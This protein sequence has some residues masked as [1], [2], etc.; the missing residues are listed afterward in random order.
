MQVYLFF[1]F[2][3]SFTNQTKPNPHFPDKSHTKPSIYPFAFVPPPPLSA[4]NPALFRRFTLAPRP[5]PNRQNYH[6]PK[7][8]KSSRVPFFFGL[9][10]NRPYRARTKPPSPKKNSVRWP[11]VR[12]SLGKPG[13]LAS[14]SLHLAQTNVRVISET[15]NEPMRKER[16][17]TFFSL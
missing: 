17:E 9:S 13:S 5:P 6:K 11:L 8:K 1:A 4:V 12:R 14:D 3:L 10:D 7:T 15:G 2:F 16:N